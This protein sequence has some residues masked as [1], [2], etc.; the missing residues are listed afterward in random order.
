MLEAE[1]PLD[2]VAVLVVE[3]DGSRPL[4]LELPTEATQLAVLRRELR[5]WL[6]SQGVDEEACHDVVIAVGEAASNAIEHPRDPRSAVFRVEGHVRRGE[7]VIRVSDSGR[8]REQSLPTDRGRGLAF[9]RRLMSD[10]VIVER[11]EGTEV[12]LRRGASADAR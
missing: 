11:D 2:D 10:V 6:R 8:W 5:P 9:M 12:V 4:F 3:T 1:V 7:V